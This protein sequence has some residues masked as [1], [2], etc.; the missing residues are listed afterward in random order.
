MA[1]QPKFILDVNGNIVSSSLQNQ[2]RS[3]LVS[4]DTESLINKYSPR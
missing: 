4:P 2:Q 1:Q 3:T